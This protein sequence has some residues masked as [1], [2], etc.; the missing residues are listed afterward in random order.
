MALRFGVEVKDLRTG[1]RDVENVPL[2]SFVAQDQISLVKHRMMSSPASPS[3]WV[4]G[5]D[6]RQRKMVVL[7]AG[8][9]ERH[10]SWAFV[11]S[12]P[13]SGRPRLRSGARQCHNR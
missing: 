5:P 13:L 7:L 4:D 9:V 10:S 12:G 1:S 11:K 8:E 3:R 6:R 2:A